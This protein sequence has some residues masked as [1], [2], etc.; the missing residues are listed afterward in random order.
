MQINYVTYIL[1]IKINNLISSTNVVQKQ[2]VKRYIFIKKAS[3]MPKK[4][5]YK[6]DR[7]LSQGNI[8]RIY[9]DFIGCGLPRKY[10]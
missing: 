2:G 5:Y 10:L 3:Q 6:V 8:V 1:K 7:H 9:L 4:V